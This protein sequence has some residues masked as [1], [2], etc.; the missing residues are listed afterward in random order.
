MNSV[1][2]VVISQIKYDSS[3]TKSWILFMLF[4]HFYGRLDENSDIFSLRL[5]QEQWNRS[6]IESIRVDLTGIFS[7]NSNILSHYKNTTAYLIQIR[8]APLGFLLYL[9]AVLAFC[10]ILSLLVYCMIKSFRGNLKKL[11]QLIEKFLHRFAR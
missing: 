11:V 9:S 6:T 5:C 10:C 7:Y 8:F 3:Q 1:E 2:D 4:F